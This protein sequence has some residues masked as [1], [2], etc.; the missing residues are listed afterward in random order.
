MFMGYRAKKH[1]S[2]NRRCSKSDKHLGK[3]DASRTFHSFWSGTQQSLK[4]DLTDESARVRKECEAKLAR[5]DST[6]ESI[7]EG[8]YRGERATTVEQR[9]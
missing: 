3:C 7:E 5:I 8:E 9:G 4:R 1:C 6:R 2:K